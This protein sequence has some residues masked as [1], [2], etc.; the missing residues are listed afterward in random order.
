MLNVSSEYSFKD[1]MTEIYLMFFSSVLPTFTT[2][3]LFLQ[4]EDPCIYLI[5]D[6]LNC[7]L[8]HLAGRF[9]PVHTIKSADHLSTINFEN[10]KHPEDMYLGLL[11]KTT[12]IVCIKLSTP[13]PHPPQKMPHPL[14]CQV[15]P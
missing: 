7:F 15:P 9:M 2:R 14:S 8:T 12:F 11:T 13:S 3:S 10:H 6:A 4:R 1:P 5:H